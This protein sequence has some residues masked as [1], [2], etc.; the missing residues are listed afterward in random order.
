MTKLTG[1]LVALT[2]VAMLSAPSAGQDK[3]VQ[4]I[5]LEKVLGN[6]QPFEGLTVTC[7]VQFH[8]LGQLDGP[9]YTKF[10]KDWY[11]N[12]SAWP[13][14]AKLW[15]KKAYKHDHQYFFIS[16]MS[17][18]ASQI[19]HAENYSRW[20][21][22]AEVSEILNGKPWFEVKG[23]RQLD[24]SINTSSLM[25]FVKGFR[26]SKDGDHALAAK[27]FHAADMSTLPADI[28]IIAMRQEAAALHAGGDTPGA[29]GRLQ[30]ALQIV[31]NDRETV[32]AIAAYRAAASAS[33][34]TVVLADKG[35]TSPTTNKKG[36]KVT[37]DLVSKSGKKEDKKSGVSNDN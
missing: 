24:T 2:F 9:V 20:V 23:L 32:D 30:A 28:R 3:E 16:R 15:K 6:P 14:S 21:V 13:D 1:G 26:A 4:N 33:A 17:E 11:Q 10:E 29:V 25:H 36:Q 7:V 8:R 5:A 22:T 27:A 34:S 12:F 37:L 31:A 18:G 19:I 35:E